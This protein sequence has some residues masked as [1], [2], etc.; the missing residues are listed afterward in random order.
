MNDKII[1]LEPAGCIEKH[2][3]KCYNYI[4]RRIRDNAEL[5]TCNLRPGKNRF[6]YYAGNIGY[7]IEEQYRGHKYSLRAL[8]LLVRRAKLVMG[9]SAVIV[10][11]APEN[12]ASRRICELAGAKYLGELEI[13]E[14]CEFFA[15][16]RMTVCRYKL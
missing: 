15:Y 11:C 6:T 10:C 5:G 14:N 8:I 4:I 16:G 12:K 9:E 2:G 13:P 3:T 7:M 1:Y